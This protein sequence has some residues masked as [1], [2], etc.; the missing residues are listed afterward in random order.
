MQ[1]NLAPVER[2]FIHVY[3]VLVLLLRVFQN[4]F[5]LLL[6]PPIINTCDRTTLHLP[7]GICFRHEKHSLDEIWIN[8][9]TPRID[10]GA[11]DALRASVVNQ[12]GNRS[13][14]RNRR[15]EHSIY[16]NRTTTTS[17]TGAEIGLNV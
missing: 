12:H 10:S 17:V 9:A 14:H 7:S 13:I 1:K 11:W 8:S 2:G 5:P 3:P 15:N 6:T 16:S 4:L